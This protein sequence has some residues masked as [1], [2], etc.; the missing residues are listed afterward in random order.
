MVLVSVLSGHVKG[1]GMSWY[2]SQGD[3]VGLSEGVSIW[4]G[5]VRKCLIGRACSKS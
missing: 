2:L 4:L 3:D 5:Y 1:V